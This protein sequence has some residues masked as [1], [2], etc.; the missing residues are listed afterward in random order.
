MQSIQSAKVNEC[1]PYN[2][3]HSG[4]C[5]HSIPIY[6]HPHSNTISTELKVGIAYA[7]LCSLDKELLQS[8]ELRVEPYLLQQC[9]LQ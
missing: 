9:R 6:N 7:S 3:A 4:A 2:C 8:P 1:L 5:S